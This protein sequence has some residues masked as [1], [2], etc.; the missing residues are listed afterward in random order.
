MVDIQIKDAIV[1]ISLNRPEKRNALNNELLRLL[2]EAIQQAAQRTDIRV[3][4]L[5]GNGLVFCAGADLEF[6]RQLGEKKVSDEFAG[7][8]SGLLEDIRTFPFPVIVNVQGACMGGANGILAAADII[9]ADVNTRFAFSEVK[10]GLVPAIISPY[11]LSKLPLSK[12]FDLLLT[13]RIFD[14]SE[15]KH[16]GLV[17]YTGIS[18]ELDFLFRQVLNQ[19]LSS[20]PEAIKLTR[21]I[22]WEHVLQNK[23][24]D[25]LQLSIDLFVNMASSAEAQEGINAFFEKRNPAWHKIGNSGIKS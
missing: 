8:L 25:N 13:G 11:V 1:T 5:N 24:E 4:V 17:T 3:L 6:I 9:I 18:G 14:A 2:R 15:A 12:A 22:I 16:A 21:K 20:A 10:L 7:L 23:W 19:I